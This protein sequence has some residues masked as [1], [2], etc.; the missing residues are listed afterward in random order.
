MLKQDSGAQSE[1]H[2]IAYSTI[3]NCWELEN[4]AEPC[5]PECERI[6][7]DKQTLFLT[8]GEKKCTMARKR[9]IITQSEN[10]CKETQ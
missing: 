9:F 6:Y 1:N 10:K 2:R 5:W 7:N 4:L 3:N 8:M